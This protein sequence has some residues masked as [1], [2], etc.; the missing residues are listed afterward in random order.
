MNFAVNL[1]FYA[2]NLCLCGKTA[3]DCTKMPVCAVCSQVYHG[4]CKECPVCATN[5]AAELKQQLADK[6]EEISSLNKS[7][8]E[9][10]GA[11]ANTS[12]LVEVTKA[13]QQTVVGL[14]HFMKEM[15]V[16]SKRESPTTQYPPAPMAQEN[17]FSFK[18]GIMPD[19]KDDVEYLQAT[20]RRLTLERDEARSGS[21]PT[22]RN[23][24]QD[25]GFGVP[26]NHPE[27]QRR[28]TFDD[29]IWEGREDS[30]LASL[31]NKT[32]KRRSKFDILKFLPESERKK[33]NA[34]DSV[35][36]LIVLLTC[37]VDEL[38]DCGEPTKGLRLHLRYV[39]TMHSQGIYELKALIGY[40][41]AIRDLADNS[42]VGE[43]VDPF[44][45]VDTSL[46]NY[47]LGYAGTKHARS[48][49]SGSQGASRGGAGA[50]GGRPNK[51]G[52]SQQ[53]KG[54]GGWKRLAADKGCCFGYSSGRGCDGG[55][56]Y[57]HQC[58]YCN[59]S[60]HGMLKCKQHDSGNNGAV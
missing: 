49:S 20:I 35:E 32:G 50:R 5:K 31:L 54:F 4:N 13:L 42:V 19:D 22:G 55:C 48:V 3:K 53:N 44:V 8:L 34:I 37:L 25:G 17:T 60:D 59:S 56:G 57:K 14:Q 10:T 11:D 40:D 24:F 33:T 36:K 2:V 23:R 58:A 45:G 46:S 18:K 41:Q 26:S 15:L 16:D 21:G 12:A 51:A 43:G 38:H 52:N 47:H 6:D 1:Q 29:D 9:S 27:R 28:S 39:A 30:L 7:L